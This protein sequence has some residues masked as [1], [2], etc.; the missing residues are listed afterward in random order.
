M[1]RCKYGTT[2]SKSVQNFNSIG[3]SRAPVPHLQ[4][5]IHI[6]ST[7]ST[8]SFFGCVYIYLPTGKADEFLKPVFRIASLSQ[9][10]YTRT[11]SL[12]SVKIPI[13]IYILKCVQEIKL[14]FN[15]LPLPLLHF[16]NAH[17]ERILFMSTRIMESMIFNYSRRNRG[18][19]M[20]SKTTGGEQWDRMKICNKG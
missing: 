9:T 13:Y 8:W 2:S 12:V 15:H 7:P 10:L 14:S 5:H 20:V 16:L 19:K 18:A 4:P 6:P 17:F 11:Y 3:V 1:V